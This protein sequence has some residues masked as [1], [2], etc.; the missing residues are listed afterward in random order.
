MR[1]M[2]KMRGLLLV[3]FI[4]QV[5]YLNGQWSDDSF[6]LHFKCDFE[7]NEVGNYTNEEFNNDC[8]IK[9]GL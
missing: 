4:I 3:V 1:G 5:I 8:I 9:D 6:D 7:N 2:C